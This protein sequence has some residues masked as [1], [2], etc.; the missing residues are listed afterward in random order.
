MLAN[1]REVAAHVRF[2][3]DVFAHTVDRRVK[4]LALCG[5]QVT[6]NNRFE[7]RA[8]AQSF[9]YGGH[10]VGDALPIILF[11]RHHNRSLRLVQIRQAVDDEKRGDHGCAGNREEYQLPS[12]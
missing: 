5:V 4:R 11:A 3:L 2:H 9:S 12:P 8:T 7:K 10:A 6:L 1:P